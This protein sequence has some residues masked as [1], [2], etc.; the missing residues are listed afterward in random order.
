MKLLNQEVFQLVSQFPFLHF[1]SEQ[2]TIVKTSFNSH[3]DTLP[4]FPEER[5]KK[6]SY[7]VMIKPYHGT[8][9]YNL[10]ITPTQVKEKVEQT[11]KLFRDRNVLYKSELLFSRPSKSF[12]I[13]Y[14][15]GHNWVESE[16]DYMPTKEKYIKGDVIKNL[17]RSNKE[18]L[19][20]I[21][22]KELKRKILLNLNRSIKVNNGINYAT[23]Y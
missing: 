11:E 7:H 22:G 5:K 8:P 4:V 23:K 20:K 10:W 9:T 15:H 6:D 19:I 12:Y 2:S 18:S 1:Y 13:K 21:S 17:P 14:K 3:V 16:I